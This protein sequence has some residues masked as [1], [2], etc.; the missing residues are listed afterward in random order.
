M[1]R[2]VVPEG[3]LRAACLVGLCRAYGSSSPIPP[4][5]VQGLI[6]DMAVT[7]KREKVLPVLEAALCWLSENPIVPKTYDELPTIGYISHSLAWGT[8]GTPEYEQKR[9][10]N[11]L[12]GMRRLLVE[13]QRRMFL[14]P[15]L[16]IPDD[17]VRMLQEK[18][19]LFGPEYYLTRLC[20]EAYRLGKKAAS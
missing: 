17:V 8:K 7:D 12:D 19:I 16:E 18:Q 3:M 2:I 5:E 1:K 14:D 4:D 20:V 6:S 15:E 13:W 10:E 9:Q 11:Y